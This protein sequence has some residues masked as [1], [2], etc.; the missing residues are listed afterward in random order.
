MYTDDAAFQPALGESDLCT[1]SI[2][3]NFMDP[4]SLDL[5]NTLYGFSSIEQGTLTNLDNFPGINL[6]GSVP[7]FQQQRQ[8]HHAAS[9]SQQ[10]VG[11]H[12]LGLGSQDPLA[13]L[14]DMPESFDDVLRLNEGAGPR[15][16]SH[17]P[18]SHDLVRPCITTDFLF[19]LKLAMARSSGIAK[20]PEQSFGGKRDVSEA[21]D[22]SGVYKMFPVL[23]CF[24]SKH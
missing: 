17:Q 16:T 12:T 22:P 9:L 3:M 4:P 10:Q 15:P 24:F 8:P 18:G 7:Q 2:S 11:Q 20:C 13:L 23:Q 6:A 21:H 5:Q 14:P 1:E 19:T